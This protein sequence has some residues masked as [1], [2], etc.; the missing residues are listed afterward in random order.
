MG[1]PS[2]GRGKESLYSLIKDPYASLQNFWFSLS[3]VQ[4]YDD[5]KRIVKT[6]HL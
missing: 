4:V 3:S 5:S 6:P 1:A 2:G